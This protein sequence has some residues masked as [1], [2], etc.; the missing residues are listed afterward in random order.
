MSDDAV[1]QQLQRRGAIAL[2]MLAVPIV[3][4]VGVG[5][6]YA[7]LWSWGAAGRAAD[8]PGATVTFEGCTEASTVIDARRDAMGLEGSPVEVAGDQLTLRT[9]LP[10]D[11]RTHA[12]IPATLAATGALRVVPASGGAPIVT[13]DDVAWVGMVLGFLDAPR[14]EAQLHREPAERLSAWMRAHPAD[15]L[16][17]SL[18]DIALPARNSSPAIDDG[19]LQLDRLGETNLAR[20]D[21]AAHAQIVLEHGPM[22]CPVRVVDVRLDAAP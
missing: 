19:L 6:A 15:K 7:V 4:I 3:S 16:L 1:S 14:A 20:M 9:R 8:G 12:V 10:A 13:E 11:P 22:P 17:V 5:A 21:F 2:L 18:D